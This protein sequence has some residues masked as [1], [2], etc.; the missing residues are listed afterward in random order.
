MS[1]L[2]GA[3]QRALQDQFDTRRIADKIE[4]LVIQ[5]Q[6][7][8]MDMAFISSRDMFWLSTIDEQGRPTVSYK[9]GDPGFVRVLDNKTLVFPL[10]DGNGM[11]YSAGNIAGTSKIGMLFMDLERPN[12]LRVQG[13]AT[14]SE[15]DPLMREFKEA[16]MLVRVNVTE[17]WPNC[18]RYVHRHQRTQASRYVPRVEC[19]TPLAGWKRIDLLQDDLPAQ[20]RGR[21][22]KEGGVISIENWMGKVAT[23]DPEA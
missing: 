8:D 21:A 3:R 1:R 23:G 17:A 16:L 22:Q 20:D 14:V 12:R 15:R 6:L 10:Y 5:P 9:G 13:E 4:A 19:E 18:P 2:Y 7:G 11:F